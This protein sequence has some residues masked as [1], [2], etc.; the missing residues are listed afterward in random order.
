MKFK[1]EVFSNYLERT[2]ADIE[3]GRT[4]DYK[5]STMN[6]FARPSSLIE[7]FLNCL[8]K[9]DFKVCYDQT[10]SRRVYVLPD[11]HYVF[12]ILPRGRRKNR[13]KKIA[14]QISLS[15][16]Q[17]YSGILVNLKPRFFQIKSDVGWMKK[18]RSLHLL[19]FLG[20][21]HL[22]AAAMLD[23]NGGHW[24]TIATGEL[25][26]EG[27]QNNLSLTFQS[28]T[29]YNFI[30]KLLDPDSQ[31]GANLYKFCQVSKHLTL[32]VDYGNY[33]APAVIPK[34]HQLAQDLIL[35]QPKNILFVSQYN[36]SGRILRALNQAAR[37]DARVTIPLQPTGDYRRHDGGFK[38]LFLKFRLTVSRK[39]NLPIRSRASHNKCL[40]VR[41]ADD[42]WSMI[43]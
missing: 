1:I 40:V 32:L 14:D 15:I 20:T 16:Q 33:G 36:P 23:K 29:A 41:H 34:I 4:V 37:D 43:F 24:A 31:V 9:N 3:A 5:I 18:L 30:K 25:S 10:L 27:R 11:G 39:I 7:R 42:S 17:K 6:L 26:S 12:R 21:S 38:F 8:L 22:K 2:I 13:Y 28:D 19:Q 35:D